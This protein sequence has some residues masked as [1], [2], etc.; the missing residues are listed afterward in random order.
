MSVHIESKRNYLLV[1]GALL[2]LMSTGAGRVS[3]DA[4]F[5]ARRR[6]RPARAA[7]QPAAS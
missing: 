6:P 2:V 3:L 5:A 1:F 7:A 4:V